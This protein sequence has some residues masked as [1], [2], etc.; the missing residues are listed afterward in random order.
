M[1][2]NKIE[3]DKQPIEW[4]LDRCFNSFF[5]TIDYYES[6]LG[7]FLTLRHLEKYYK[8]IIIKVIFFSGFLI[9]LTISIFLEDII[10]FIISISISAIFIYLFVRIDKM[11][12]N[13]F[14]YSIS[15]YRQKRKK[16]SI[17]LNQ[18]TLIFFNQFLQEYLNNKNYNER[19]NQ[20]FEN[21]TKKITHYSN[22]FKAYSF[23][24]IRFGFLLG[25]IVQLIL[26]IINIYYEE[27]SKIS[28]FELIP[29]LIIL[30][31]QIFYFTYIILSSRKRRISH[32]KVFSE[33]AEYILILI[34]EAIRL[35][36]RLEEFPKEE[37][38]K[39]KIPEIIKEIAEKHGFETNSKK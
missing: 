35:K 18:F 3:V 13:K 23:Y 6:E 7:S 31:S 27:I 22:V 36:L 39:K 34:F 30:G 2:E 1:I 29:D 19:Y 33:L 21:I 8:Y 37:E 28:F 24:L 4:Y 14:K 17:F 26:F 15:L 20:K 10:L 25:I 38:I 9:A 32:D 11:T 16:A 5:S 12:Y